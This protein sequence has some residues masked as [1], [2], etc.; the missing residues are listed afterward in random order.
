MLDIADEL[1]RWVEQ[2]RD[3]AVAT[4]V[5]VGGSAPRQPGAALAVDGEG[6][7]DR[8]G[9]RRMRGGGGLRAV[10]AG[11]GGR[12]HRPR[13]LRLQRRRRLR[14]RPDLRRRHR[15]PR[16]PGPR[17]GHRRG[18]AL[19][20]TGA[21]R[22][23]GR[24]R[25]RRSPGWSSGPDDLG[26]A[27]LVRPDG[28][29][30][31]GLGGHPELDRTA[32]AETRALLDAGRTGVLGD[33][34]EQGSPLRSAAHA[35]RGVLRAAAPH[36]RLRRHRLRLR[37]GAGRRVPRLP[38]DGVRRP[39]GLRHP[40]RFPDADEIVV[41]WPHRYLERTDVDARTVLCVLTHDAKFDVPLL[42]GPAAPGRLRRRHGLPAHPSGPQR[43]AARSRRDRAGTGPA[44]AR[45]S[46]WTSARAPPRRRRC[47]SPRRSSPT[48]AAA[49]APR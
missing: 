43:A 36:D 27:L 45:P 30:E 21:G 14:R 11:A 47:P 44:A 41:D 18:A 1:H 7:A 3:F 15:H 42:G 20:A 22:R 34:S 28:S 29:H 35:A 16:H 49:A 12:R 33:R 19:F 32:V 37:A 40:G 2:G 31:G 8:L 48:G 10:P 24:R 38:R 46:A 39:P 23:R 9:L 17:P 25:R 5:A 6:T 13:A 4:V 26:R